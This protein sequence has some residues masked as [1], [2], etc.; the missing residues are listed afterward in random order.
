M[1]W[2]TDVQTQPA[3]SLK[4]VR[5]LEAQGEEWQPAVH[6]RELA[7]IAEIKRDIAKV[8]YEQCRSL[9]KLRGI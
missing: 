8:Q 7:D 3:A 5:L 6:L 2:F 9:P 4:L 1:L